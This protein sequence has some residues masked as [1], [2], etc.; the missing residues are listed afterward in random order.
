MKLLKMSEPQER[1]PKLISY[2]NQPI[3]M[4]WAREFKALKQL[5][6]TRRDLMKRLIRNALPLGFKR[7]H[8]NTHCQIHCLLCHT[9]SVETARHIFWECEFAKETWDRLH[10]PWR[11]QSRAQIGWKEVLLGYDVRA[12]PVDNNR[13]EQLCRS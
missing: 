6:P 9:N 10:S 1:Q 11:N 13:A 7:I 2:N 3:T 4:T 8:W 5:A 12:G